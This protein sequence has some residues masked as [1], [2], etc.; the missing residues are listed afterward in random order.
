M[1]TF[2]TKTSNESRMEASQSN[3]YKKRGDKV[4]VVT[5]A[6]TCH[7]TYSIIKIGHGTKQMP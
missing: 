5:L 1:S 7:V 6:E 2:F 3:F 4:A